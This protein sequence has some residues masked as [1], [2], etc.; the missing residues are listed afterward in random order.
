MR[1]LLSRYNDGGPAAVAHSNRGR[2]AENRRLLTREQEAELRDWMDQERPSKV[3]LAAW[4]AERCGKT[5]DSTSLWIYRR[6]YESH[7]REGRK[8]G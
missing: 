5:P 1:V 3:E 4:I 8:A 7:S 6:G 2:I